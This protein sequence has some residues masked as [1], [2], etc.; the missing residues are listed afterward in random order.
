MKINTENWNFCYYKSL[1]LKAFLSLG[2]EPSPLEDEAQLFFMITVTDPD[3]R[4][5]YQGAYPRLEEAL[6]TLNERYGHW[7]FVSMEGNVRE[8]D[9]GCG[10]CAAH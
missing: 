2:G 8:D 1:K 5:M 6:S 7:E 4:E 3:D 9:G 10:T